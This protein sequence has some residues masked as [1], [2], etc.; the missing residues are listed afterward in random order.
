MFEQ[1][2]AKNFLNREHTGEYVEI[3]FDTYVNNR[4]KEEVLDVVTPIHYYEGG[5][6]EPLILVHGI[7]QS[8]YTWRK[9]IDS[10]KDS[11]HVYAMDLPGHGFSGKPEMSY[12]VEEFALS[13]EAFM[14][15]NK[16]IAASFCAFGEAAAYVLDFAIHNPERTKGIVLIS[17]VLS[18]GGGLLKGRGLN[19]VFGS[20][21]SR[22][23]VSP[24]V[25]RNVL[26]ECYFDRTLVT[27]EVVNEYYNGMADKDFK[28]ISRMCM[29]NFI[30]DGVI[31]NTYQVKNPVLVIIASDDKITGG[32]NSDFLTLGFE[33]GNMLD[34]RNCGYLV[35]EEKPEKVDEA[36][37]KFLGAK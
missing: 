29:G 34:V 19:S 20:A 25:V 27:E 24:Q 23:M 21:A 32:R 36:I 28:V 13:I 35:H 18:G 31:A 16:I 37:K 15:V 26:E 3:E 6:G 9:N 22:M 14:N 1:I 17:P 11:F 10:L 7:G 8:S 30:D 12:S 33:N 2:G 5:E 4:G